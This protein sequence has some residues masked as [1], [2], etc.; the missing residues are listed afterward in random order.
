MKCVVNVSSH[1]DCVTIMTRNLDVWVCWWDNSEWDGDDNAH[2]RTTP[3]WLKR[4][5]ELG[6]FIRNLLCSSSCCWFCMNYSLI[7]NQQIKKVNTVSKGNFILACKVLLAEVMSGQ[8][9]QMASYRTQPQGKAV[10]DTAP[11]VKAHGVALCRIHWL[12]APIWY[13]HGEDV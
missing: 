4:D 7:N 1:H 5:E 8:G 11:P 13:S 6:G 10:T 9:K 2:N 12:P 3:R